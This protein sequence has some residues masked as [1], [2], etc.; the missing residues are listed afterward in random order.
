M[1]P[2]YDNLVNVRA[3]L[4]DNLEGAGSFE[5]HIVI[6]TAAA[7]TRLY[8]KL[9]TSASGYFPRII[10][11]FDANR[12]RAAMDALEHQETNWFFEQLTSTNQFTT[13]PYSLPLLREDE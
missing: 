2:T 1:R 11:I 7:E 4:L 8:K 3:L 10:P 5:T 9:E 6:F 13:L 12:L